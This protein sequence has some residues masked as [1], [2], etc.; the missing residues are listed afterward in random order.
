MINIRMARPEDEGALLHV[1]L[2]TGN[3]GHDASPLHKDPHLIGMIYAAP[4]LHFSKELAFVAEQDG[5]VVGYTVCA[6]DSVTFQAR[7]KENWWPPL[8]A[9]Y[10]THVL[11][12][13][14]PEDQQS[15]SAYA[16]FTDHFTR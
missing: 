6:V 4:Y 10:H 12:G 15:L 14:N 1:G 11:D 2:S 3:A 5:Q 9:Q 7:L 8:R 16:I 13:A